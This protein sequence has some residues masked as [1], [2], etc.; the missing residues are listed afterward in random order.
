[1]S[2]TYPTQIGTTGLTMSG[3]DDDGFNA[4]SGPYFRPADSSKRFVVAYDLNSLVLRVELSLDQGA[5]WAEQDGANRPAV[6]NDSVAP[7]FFLTVSSC[8]SVVNP[9][10][11]LIVFWNTDQTVRVKAFDM[12]LNG[13]LGAWS[14]TFPSAL[15]YLSPNVGIAGFN[16]VHRSDNVAVITLGSANVSSGG[17]DR[18]YYCTL[19]VGTGV[20]SA[21]LAMGPIADGDNQEY[22]CF[23]AALGDANAVHFLIQNRTQLLQQSLH[24]DGTLAA[25]QVIVTGVH[26]N[27]SYAT[28]GGSRLL[29][30]GPNAGRREIFLGAQNQVGLVNTYSSYRGLSAD[31]IAFTNEVLFPVSIA[32]GFAL[33]AQIALV[34]IGGVL[35]GFSARVTINPITHVPVAVRFAIQQNFGAGWGV[36][37]LLG[38]DLSTLVIRSS[39][40]DAVALPGNQWAFVFYHM[41]ATGSGLPT[42]GGIG[43]WQAAAATVTLTFKGKKVLNAS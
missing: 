35:Y 15:V 28:A 23:G 34:D 43:F 42:A 2:V 21:L 33:S 40:M 6:Q 7:F 8:Q 27:L 36:F 31:V 39:A 5:T 10:L 22:A 13:G 19:N 3:G 14:T 20:Y 12:S 1:M 32:A 18:P 26:P 37:S 38:P 25:L 41:S 30:S 11:I 24:A 9:N 16:I 4:R 17:F 29:T